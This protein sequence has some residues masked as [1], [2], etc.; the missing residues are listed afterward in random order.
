MTGARRRPRR[1]SRPDGIVLA[2]GAGRRM[3][4]PKAP[5]AFAGGTLVQRAVA[6]MAERCARVIV[7]ARPE[8][9]L[10]AVDA[11]VVLDRPGPD[12]PLT[13][14][15]TGLVASDAAEVLVLG[16]DLPFAGPLL[17]A[18]IAHDAAAAVAHADG[19]IQPLCAR[20]P[21]A[22]ALAAADALLA[23]GRLAA[24]GLPRPSGPSRST[25]AGTPSPTS[26]TPADLAGARRRAAGAV[27][28][29]PGDRRRAAGRAHARQGAITA[30]PSAA[31]P[32]SRAA[33][34]AGC[35]PAR[36]R[37]RAT[38]PPWA[39]VAGRRP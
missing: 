32:A 10:P 34:P 7:V 33:P 26:N 6:L 13:G 16:C 39:P 8:V 24:R 4:G 29:R 36:R 25:T 2:G 19:H 18:L 22:A 14:I 28:V 5:I 3:G 20:Y 31:P 15:A 9:P 23:A 27:G 21:R 1:P 30:Q 11:A 12:C 35:A 17:D 37:A 38:V